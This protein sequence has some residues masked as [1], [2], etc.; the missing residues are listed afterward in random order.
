MCSTPRQFEDPDACSPCVPA[1]VGCLPRGVRG[2]PPPDRAITEADP[3]P[4][5][6]AMR[7]GRRALLQIACASMRSWLGRDGRTAVRENPALPRRDCQ[8]AFVRSRPPRHHHH[9]EVEPETSGRHAV[10]GQHALHEEEYVTGGHHFATVGEQEKRLLV[11][12]IVQNAGHHIHVSPGRYCVERRAR[13]NLASIRHLGSLEDRR[14]SG[15]R[16]GLVK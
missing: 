4:S 11:R 1:P 7:I 8:S 9:D 15:Q 3:D 13:S 6:R 10:L 5:R 2:P 16:R 12:P 14:R